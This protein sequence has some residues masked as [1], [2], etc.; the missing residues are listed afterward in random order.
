MPREDF[1]KEYMDVR[2]KTFKPATIVSAFQK[3]G[4]WPVNCDVFTDEDY[5][6]SIPT[7]TSSFHIPNSFPLSYDIGNHDKSDNKSPTYPTGNPDSSGSDDESSIA[8]N[9]NVAGGIDDNE[10]QTISQPLSE[11]THTASP[12]PPLAPHSSFLGPNST[13]LTSCVPPVHPVPLTIR[14]KQKC[15]P[16]RPTT[17]SNQVQDQLDTLLQTCGDLSQQIAKLHS[18]NLTLKA[19]CVLAGTEIQDLKRWLN[20]DEGLRLAEEQEALWA[21]EEQKKHAAREKREAMEAEREEQRRQRDPNAPFTGALTSKTKAD[22]QDIAQVLG[23]SIGGQKKAIVARINAHFDS[24][25]IL[26][27]DPCFEGIFNRLRRWPTLQTEDETLNMNPTASVRP[28][29]SVPMPIPPLPA[30]LS[31]NIVNTLT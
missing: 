1:V 25:P 13:P 12:Q 17:S 31:S 5:A 22:L 26:R 30:P 7:S 29:A 18:E 20:S 10:L 28:S 4:C 3:S 23:L 6:P 21:A 11:S 8:S 27:D 16:G 15:L 19:H 9:D 24:Y 14:P 2:S